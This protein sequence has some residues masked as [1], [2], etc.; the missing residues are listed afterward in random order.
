MT[1]EEMFEEWNKRVTAYIER[2]D[3]QYMERV[4]TDEELLQQ[5]AMRGAMEGP[6]EC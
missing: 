2:L 4:E 1:K 5:E 6:E 3:A